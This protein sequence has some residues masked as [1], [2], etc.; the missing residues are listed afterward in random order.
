MDQ[1]PVELG[2]VGSVEEPVA[3]VVLSVAV[4]L[5]VVSGWL[6][7]LETL[8]VDDAV[9]VTVESMLELE[10]LE[11]DDPVWGSVEESVMAEDVLS[12]G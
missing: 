7:V 9:I 12:F 8:M 6:L 2:P 4:V 10:V 11:V 1:V 5:S 3:G